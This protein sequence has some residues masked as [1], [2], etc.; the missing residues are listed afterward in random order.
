[1]GFGTFPNPQIQMPNVEALLQDG[2][3]IENFYTFRFCA[4]SRGSFLTGRYPWR[5]PSTRINFI[6]SYVMDGT[7]LNYT[8]IPARLASQGY[9][10]YHIGKCEYRCFRPAT[11][12]APVVHATCRRC[13][14]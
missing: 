14:I 7:P 11:W 4:P 12:S 13:L 5:L 3:G 10:S 1:M 9:V 8:M 6:P 2:L